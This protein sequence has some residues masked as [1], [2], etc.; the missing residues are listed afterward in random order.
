MSDRE[1]SNLHPV[2]SVDSIYKQRALC[3]QRRVLAIVMRMDLIMAHTPVVVM[4]V[5]MDQGVV[6]EIVDL[7]GGQDRARVQVT[8]GEITVQG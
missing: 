8:D 6:Q 3:S 2:Q 5:K 4:M 1:V 7:L